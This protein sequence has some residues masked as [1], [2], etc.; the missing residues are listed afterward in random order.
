MGKSLIRRGRIAVSVTAMS[1]PANRVLFSAMALAAACAA[2]AGCS[3]STQPSAAPTVSGTAGATQLDACTLIS[4]A[5]IQQLLGKTIPG[6][7]NNS[8]LVSECVWE[9]KET[10][11]S[12]TLHIGDSGTAPGNKLADH[13][14]IGMPDSMMGKPG[15]DGMRLEGNGTVVFPAGNRENYVQVAVLAKVQDGTADATAIDL[16]KKA[17][18]QIPG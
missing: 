1:I 14:D 17:A 6:K 8:S 9:D 11:N 5:D 12:V 15:P 3:S 10:Y 2:F 7:Q 18:P 13:S 4:V 16:A